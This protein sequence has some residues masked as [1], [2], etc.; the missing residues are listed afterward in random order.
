MHGGG[1]PR[2]LG[3]VSRWGGRRRDGRTA[4]ADRF[5][6]RGGPS[7]RSRPAGQYRCSQQCAWPAGQPGWGWSPRGTGR[8]GATGQ[9]RLPRQCRSFRFAGSAGQQRS[10]RQYRCPRRQ[11]SPRQ[12]RPSRQWWPPRCD[13]RDRVTGPRWHGGAGRA[14]CAGFGW[15]SRCSGPV[16]PYRRYWSS[17]H[18]R[19]SGLG[20][21]SRPYRGHLQPHDDGER[22]DRRRGCRHP[23]AVA[24]GCS[25]QRADHSHRRCP[26]LEPSG[27][28]GWPS[29]RNRGAGRGW[30]PR[31]GG[32]TGHGRYAGTAG[33]HGCGSTG[34][35]R[36]NGRDRLARSSGPSRHAGLAGNGGR[37]WPAGCCW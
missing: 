22:H 37:G 7:R 27:G 29:G 31:R 24:R 16:W 13:R 26:R 33:Q 15:P 2:Y 5:A 20:W 19:C 6:G 4:G 10:P 34:S 21:S 11:R 18:P 35:Y 36:C 17:G 1:H 3:G 8:D 28:F 32:D 14:G 9:C 25:R 12:C 23:Y 30:S